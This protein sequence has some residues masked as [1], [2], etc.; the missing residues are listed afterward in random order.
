MTSGQIFVAPVKGWLTL[1]LLSV[2]TIVSLIFSCVFVNLGPAVIFIPVIIACMYYAK[3]GFFFSV[4]VACI[5]F[6]LTIAISSDPN[7]LQTAAI[8]VPFFILVAGVI[9]YISLQR[10]RGEEALLKNTEELQAA[11]EQLTAAG[12]ELKAQFDA[13]VESE[14]IIRQSEE[15]LNMA[16]EIGHTG[17]W[18]SDVLTNT[19][20]G[21]EEL[22]RI[23]GIHGVAGNFPMETFEACIPERERVHQSMVDLVHAGKEY[24]L[25]FAINPADGSVQK[26]IHSI[27]RLEKDARG[28]PLRILGV[29]QD[30]TGRKQAEATLLKNTEDLHAAYEELTATDEEMRLN[31]DA[32]GRS[33][34]ALRE[35]EERY[36]LI[37]DASLDYIYSYD[38]TGR[39]A[40]A[41]RSLCAA[42][43][44]RTDQVLGRTHAGLGFPDAQCRDWDELHRR[45]FETGTT[46]TA[47]TSTP[48]PD[49][50]IRQYEVV[51]N[52]LHDSAG[53]ITGIAGTTRDITERKVAEG[54]LRKNAEELHAA[55]EELT[56]SEEEL[57]SNLVDLTRQEEALRESEE[58]YR[59]L[60]DSAPDGITVIDK[61]GIIVG[62]SQRTLDVTGYTKEELLGKH[63]THDILLSSKGVFSEKFPLLQQNKPVEGEI[64]IERKDG[65]VVWIWRK[66][67]P[68]PDHAGKF[69]G[70]LLYDRDI[71]ERKLAEDTLLRVNQK[72]NVLSQLTRKDL[73]SQTFVLN[74]YLELLKHQLAGQDHPIDTLEKGI[75][76]VQSIHKT[77]EYSKDYQD[78]GAKPPRWQ[79]VKTAMLLGLSHISIGKI[80]HSLE[81]GNLEIFAD[82]L[83]ELVCQRL[84]ENSV[85]HGDHVTVI[86]VWHT[87][88]PEGATIFFEDDG[89]GIPQEKKEQIFLRIEGT[90]ASRGSLIFVREILD[91]TGITI[92]E[93]GEQGEGARFEMAVSKG[94]WRITEVK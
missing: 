17:S 35:S 8:R 6:I 79:N 82:P 51:L 43:R 69:S 72:L 73:T 89:I 31:L 74:G 24:N 87:I 27:A 94:A 49:G 93:T 29:A 25:E 85:K 56:A 5:Y 60:F 83:L 92:K 41:N 12:E 7:V 67:F 65:S 46:V 13:L 1:I 81:T 48:M 22:L 9:T 39:F 34:R 50:T 36:R 28:N 75:Q 88:T 47:F 66:G 54:A 61:T 18:E 15:R 40:S 91:I 14:R 58:R 3:R 62:C 45:V 16:Q 42:M 4:F 71:S 10:T 80:Q 23:F 21:S 11:N 57:R 68:L 37:N 84:F 70:A 2:L 30:I 64:Q 78:M 86:R 19:A 20:W 77:I 26:I 55:Y 53:A 52:P 63:T 32:L 38:K 33:E 44:L 90:S 59:Y 76:A